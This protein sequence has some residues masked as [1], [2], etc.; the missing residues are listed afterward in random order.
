MYYNHNIYI[1]SFI[2]KGLV[3]LEKVSIVKCGNYSY[4]K[5]EKKV[6]QCLGNIEDLNKQIKRGSKVLVKPDL[7]KKNFLDEAVTT[8]PYIVEGVVRYLQNL[9]CEV[10]IGDSPE[11][12]FD[13]KTLRTT[14]KATGM[15]EVQK[16]TGCQLNFDTSYVE[17]KNNNGKFLKSMKIVK[18]FNE[19]DLIISVAKL[20]THT[21]MIYTG[22]VKNLFGIIPGLTKADYR[23]RMNS[24]DDFSNALVDVSEYIKPIFS[25]IDA[26]EGMEGDGPFLGDKRS[27]GLIMASQNIYA[28]DM[29]AS[30]IMGIEPSSIPTINT[31]KEREIFNGDIDSIEILGE[32]LKDIVVKPFKSSTVSSVY[33][34][35]GKTPKFLEK[36]ILNN[37]VPRPIFN[38]DICISCKTCAN[39]CPS[40][41]IDISSGYPDV[42]LKQCIRCF[43]CYELCP[44]GAVEIKKSKK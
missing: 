9:G 12:P 1:F 42:D 36:W 27:V 14:Y 43:S 20:K 38:H 40:K 11:G 2:V 22:G 17:V 10:I 37:L 44:K 5:V 8:H 29:V 25:I 33:S 21:M 3:L 41:S 26:I 19:V 35:R 6:F 34:I 4:K 30:Y 16:R 28:L 13:E 18:S 7:A 32:E 15:F 31:A 23:L 39:N 24:I